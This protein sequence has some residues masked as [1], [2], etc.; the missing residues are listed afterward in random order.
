V[1]VWPLNIESVASEERLQELRKE[2][3]VTK[4]LERIQIQELPHEVSAA[5]PAALA[6]L[7]EVFGWEF[8]GD[9][10][11]TGHPFR[12]FVFNAPWTRSWFVRVAR[13]IG[14]LQGLPGHERLIKDLQSPEH[15]SPGLLHLYQVGRA[16]GHGL[17]V[18][19]E[20]RTVGLK[21]ADLAVWEN[22][23]PM[24]DSA[25]PRAGTMPATTTGLKHLSHFTVADEPIRQFAPLLC[26]TLAFICRSP[27]ALINRTRVARIG[28]S[29]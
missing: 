28:V 3:S 5:L 6:K 11:A 15:A 29:A 2:F 20:P 23:Y 22:E 17:H 24:S 13:M 26:P 4:F 25:S 21:S 8:I 19:L 27:P 18:E 9:A 1:G 12:Q 10:V 14:Q 7:R 16:L